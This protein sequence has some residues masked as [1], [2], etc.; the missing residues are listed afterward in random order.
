MTLHVSIMLWLPLAL[1]AIGLLAPA[2]LAGRIALLGTA[3][4]L[5]YAIT[6]AVD[7]DS[8][9]SGLQYVTDETWIGE[10]GISYK[11]GIDGLNLFLVL[12]TAIL[13]FAATLW[14]TRR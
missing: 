11:L 7:F 2:R 12:L 3:L 10:L 6:Y 14:S 4:V 9:N 5:G 13:W 1:G 8:A